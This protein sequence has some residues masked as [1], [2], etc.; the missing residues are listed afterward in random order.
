M[1]RLME[2]KDYYNILGVKPDEDKQAIKKAYRRLARKYHPDVSKE[3]DAEI[4][5]KEVSEA[6]EVLGDKVKRA[7][8]D[9]LRQY[10][11]TGERFSPPP[12]WQ[13]NANSTS[14]AS[15][16]DF[17]EFFENI[18][19]GGFG[20]SGTGRGFSG[21]DETFSSRGQDIEISLP[22]FLED[23]LSDEPKTIEYQL[24]KYDETGRREDIKKTLSVKIPKGVSDGERIRLKGQGALGFG[25][26]GHGDLYLKIK[27]VPHPVFDV[28]GKDLNVTL[29]VSPWEAA[30]GTIVTVPTLTGKI[31]LT[32][33]ANSQSGSR[34]RVKG[35]GLRG[36]NTNGDLFVI[37]NVVI[38][39]QCDA[40]TK[41]LWQQ[42]AKVTDFDPR[43]ELS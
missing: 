32:I 5:F 3:H 26:A 23:T 17:S 27:L 35:K 9:Q 6:Y 15:S 43:K 19:G 29:P 1:D 28:T 10:G 31:K 7:E 8:Y 13:T 24:P 33:P 38:P 37:L 22:I 18:F 36:K 39:E 4:K 20:S 30:L 11:Q 42:L 14:H 12:G 21:A 34:L 40:K 16:G 2:F 41:E 25:S